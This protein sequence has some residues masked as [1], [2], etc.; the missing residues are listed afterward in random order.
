MRARR[1]VAVILVL[2]T[3]VSGPGFVWGAEAPPTPPPPPAPGGAPTPAPFSE[4]TPARVSYIDN[5]VSFWR[6]GAQ[7][8][9]PA[10]LN[11]P[12]APGDVLY[13]GQGGNVEIQLGPRAFA[14]AAD[15]THIGLDNQEPDY[16][17]LRVTA[18]HAALDLRELAAGHTVE[19]DTPNAAFTIERPGYYHVDVAQESTTFRTHRG[20]SAAMTP[21]GGTARP[22]AANQQVVVAGTDSPRVDTGP[23]PELT[24][25]DRWNYQRT[26]YLLQPAKAQY[27]SPT[28][29]GVEALERYGSWRTVETYGPVWVPLGVP[30][31]WVPYSTGRWIWDPR[32]GW[33]WLDDAPWGWAPY[34]Y[35][36]WVFVGS[37]WAWAPGP[38]IVRPAYAPALVVFLGG[39]T[40]GVGRPLYWAPLGWG[41]PVFPWWGR[42][43]FVGV[44]W[45]GGWGGPR[46]VNNVVVNRT[47]N[48]NVTNITVY[49][50]VSVTNAVVGVPTER[51]GRGPVQPVR[52]SQVQAQQLTPVRGVLEVRPAAASVMPATGP[53]VKPPAAVQSRPVV[54]TRQPQDFTPT[55]RAHGLA[56]TSAVAPA[57]APRLVPSPRPTAAPQKAVVAP[58]AAPGRAP[59]A[60]PGTAVPAAPGPRRR[61]DNA[62]ERP[63]SA[64]PPGSPNVV[65]PRH[66][67]ATRPDVTS[68]P[69]PKQDNRPVRDAERGQRQVPASPP[70]RPAQE[71]TPSRPTPPPVPSPP[72][73]QNGASQR[74]RE[75]ARPGPKANLSTPAPAPA[76]RPARVEPPAQTQR[77]ERGAPPTRSERSERSEKN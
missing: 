39:V 5:Q 64:A 53:T 76:E 72:A 56:A 70:A 61:N 31:G 73:V 66:Q 50:N 60:P 45:W 15:G 29:Y 21:A 1:I 69:E 38:V 28:V 27:V 57:A 22:I 20:G 40:V 11:T 19:L 42:P 23:A 48:I 17:Q 32:F 7:D 62:G 33:T 13:A 71:A 3:M 58:E 74:G 34:H 65:S 18:G 46:V 2:S 26:D 14:R 12:L 44:A 54:A 67:D 52:V 41:E 43:G 59:S 51:F 35:G 4:A 10:K 77:P 68:R 75:E 37:Y 47:T 25:W 6:P 49:R 36:R 55:L 24:A 8:W 63:S 9:A 16:V 30:G